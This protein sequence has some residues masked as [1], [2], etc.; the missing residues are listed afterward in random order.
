V[1][2]ILKKYPTKTDKKIFVYHFFPILIKY[3]ATATSRDNTYAQD[4][5]DGKEYEDNLE[6]EPDDHLAGRTWST[7]TKVRR[8]LGEG[9]Y[10]VGGRAS[11]WC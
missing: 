4:D 3:P 5:S 6:D 7:L 1:L 2:P 8:R 10:V 11:W 9:R